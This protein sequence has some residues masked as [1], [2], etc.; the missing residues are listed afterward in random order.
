V[1]RIKVLHVINTLGMGGAEELI[2]N[3]CKHINKE[4]FLIEVVVLESQMYPIGD[5]LIALGIKTHLLNCKHSYLDIRKLFKLLKVIKQFQPNIIH[6]H[7]F[8]SNLYARIA[9]IIARVPILIIHEHNT[10]HE[11]EKFFRL[12]VYA[13]QLLSKYT[14][15]IITISEAVQDFTQKQERIESDK[16]I[17]IKN[18]IDTSKFNIP[19][20]QNQSALVRKELGIRKDEMMMICVAGFREQK[21]HNYLIDAINLLKYKNAK[22]ILVGDGPLRKD[23]EKKVGN[24]DLESRVHFLGMRRDI[25]NLL[26][27]A[28]LFVLPSLWEG[29]G[30]VIIEAMASGLPVV[31][32]KVGGIPE[33]ITENEGYLVEPGNVDSL[34]KG[35]EHAIERITM[36]GFDTHKMRIKAQRDFDIKKYIERIEKL[37]SEAMGLV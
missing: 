11:K 22:L 1:Q 2:F 20:W 8:D 27:A 32:T 19:D 21:G 18:C 15:K 24:Y 29:Q 28:D 4:R 23:I 35:I 12:P 30:L 36:K 6:S 37:Y 33:Y 26:N 13:D 34:V 3:I 10:F 16:F 17:I 14:Y 31:A 7:L 9:G 25:P 5:E